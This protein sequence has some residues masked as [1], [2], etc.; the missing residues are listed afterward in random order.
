MS[1]FAYGN[2]RLHARR[3][4]LLDAADYEGLLGDDIDGLLAALQRTPY[5]PDVER[6]RDQAAL[7]RLH[8]TIRAHLGRS[9]EEMRGFYAD[10]ARELVNLMLS[11]FDLQNVVLMLRA[12]AGTERPAD[13]ALG[14]LLP[15]GWLVEP[16]ARE[17]LRGP[18]LA[19]AVD[20]LARGTPVTE[21]AGA[22]R[23]ALGEYERTRNLAALEQAVLAAHAT[24]VTATLASAGREARTL[25]RF[26]RRAIDER[27]LVVALRLRDARMSGAAVDVSPEGTLLPGGFAPVAGF[28]AAVRAPAPV[29]AISALPRIAGSGWQAPLERWAASGDL[30]LLERDLERRRIVDAAALF[31]MGDPL[32][33]DVPIAFAAA[34]QSEA[35][36]LRLLGEASARGI[37]PEVVRRELLWPEAHA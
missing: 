2:T 24:R 10:R 27:N 14:A 3:A 7:R 36:N 8:K 35:R 18:E 19:G 4:E 1:D 25:L 11:R 5:G 16:L 15:M 26:A 6:A 34:K 29:A 30:P 20:L 33:L 9:L 13:E 37:H 12:R 28:A 22:L 21:Q 23:A 32:T 17:I 31:R